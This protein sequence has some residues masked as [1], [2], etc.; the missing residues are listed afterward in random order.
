[1][2]VP[3]FNSSCREGRSSSRAARTLRRIS[4]T[5]PGFVL[6]FTVFTVPAHADPDARPDTAGRSGDAPGITGDLPA[7]DH[8][9]AHEA[10]GP[11][12]S[13]GQAP[14]AETP[15]AGVPQG[16]PADVP[17]GPPADG[18]AAEAPAAKAQK[19]VVC[20]YVRK[21]GVAE[22][23]SHIIVVNENALK[24]KGFAGTFPFAFS[25]AHS[26]SVAVRYADKGEQGKDISA[27][28]CPADE[29]PGEEPPGGEEEE[30]P[31]GDVGGIIEEAPA[32]DRD[33]D[34]ILPRTGASSDLQLLALLGGL[35]GLAGA[36]VVA[37]SQ[38]SGRSSL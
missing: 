26:S 36:W 34:V 4:V 28:V 25:D 11:P 20:K 12:E 38:R 33:A 19:V 27:S 5:V 9:A 21:P 3:V 31:P 2:G 16:P 8:A 35:S 17:Q 30:E 23:F 18:P 29:P 10:V 37:R 24:G 1:M 14:P 13:A 7:P 22:T 32:G 15:P 6:A